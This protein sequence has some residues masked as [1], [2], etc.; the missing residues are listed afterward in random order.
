MR[1]GG[2]EKTSLVDDPG[3]IATVLFT[4][5]CNLRCPYCHNPELVPFDTGA[6]TAEAEAFLPLL[7]ERKGFIDGVVL[8]GGEPTLQEG[9]V[10]FARAVR[11]RGMRLKLDTNGSRPAVLAGL[12]EE[13]LVDAVAM[14]VKLPLARYG[15]LTD[16]AEVGE[17]VGE[18]LA[19][20]AAGGL[21][22][23]FRATLVP[24]LHSPADLQTMA[25]EIPAGETVRVAL[26]R[27]RAG[28][29]LDPAYR[30]SREFTNDEMHRFEE[31]F[32]EAGHPTELRL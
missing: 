24:G 15:E 4:Q 14:D 13:R 16:E 23:E 27:F 25:R 26:Q 17:R 8:T 2:V 28:R 1:I 19:L 11:E 32:R 20:L 31:I 21:P 6:E 30:E 9:L 3:R 22:V 7:E 18:S 5:G 12:L 29:T 10:P